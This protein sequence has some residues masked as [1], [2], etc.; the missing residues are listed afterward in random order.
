MD[1]KESRKEKTKMLQDLKTFIMRG[2]VIDMAV[3][4]IIGMAFGAVVSSLVNDVI[5]PP[6]GLALGDVDFANLFVILKEGLTPGPYASLADAQAAGAV[7]INYGVF[8]NTVV[9]LLIIAAVVFFLIVRPV[10][11]MQARKKAEEPA[12]ATTKECPYC[13]TSIPIQASRCPNCTSELKP[14]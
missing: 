3:G 9:Y 11:R 6:I 2:N 1:G 4:I 5:M 12:A 7:T 10:A 8:I 13:F 14:A